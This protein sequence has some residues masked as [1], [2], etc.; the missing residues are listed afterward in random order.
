MGSL[1]LHKTQHNSSSSSVASLSIQVSTLIRLMSLCHIFKFRERMWLTQLEWRL[2]RWLPTPLVRWMQKTWMRQVRHSPWV[3]NIRGCQKLSN[4]AKNVVRWYLCFFLS[5]FLLKQLFIWLY[6]V[7]VV[8]QGIFSCSLGTLLCDM[9]DLVPCQGL[10][11][12]PL[13]WEHRSL[14]TGPPGKSCKA[15]S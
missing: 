4:Q 10:N 2:Y 11:L 14:A 12:G 6:Q 7:L 1:G 15:V 8:E 13:H 5:F 3:K 9:C